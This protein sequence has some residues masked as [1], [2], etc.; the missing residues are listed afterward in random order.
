MNIMNRIIQN[1]LV[2]ATAIGFMP[3]SQAAIPQNGVF[4]ACYVTRT[5]TLRLIDTAKVQTCKAG[6]LPISWNQVGPV[7]SAG[8]KGDPGAMGPAGPQGP[9]G[10]TGAVGPQ[11]PIGATGPTGPQ[12]P[13]GPAGKDG[14]DGPAVV[15]VDSVGTVVGNVIGVID[16]L[17]EE[18]SHIH[19]VF[20]AINI[21]EKVFTVAVD[22]NGY[23]SGYYGRLRFSQPSCQGQAYLGS[24][25]PRLGPFPLS[26]VRIPFRDGDGNNILFAE[27]DGIYQENV[28]YSSTETDA[29]C[30]SNWGGTMRYAMPVAPIQNLDEL[31][32]PPFEVVVQ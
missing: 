24:S 28:A 19:P 13:E 32:T 17:V 31:F 21:N 29:G 18:N 5:G 10:A 1:T 20:V 3:A 2:A 30:S 11:G 6:E 7:G 12:G 27:T 9:I 22:R 14:K 23:W 25:D 15:V 26:H 4:T 8:P 16:F